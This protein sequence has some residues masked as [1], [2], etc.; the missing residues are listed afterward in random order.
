MG[1]TTINDVMAAYDAF[2]APKGHDIDPLNPHGLNDWRTTENPWLPFMNFYSIFTKYAAMADPQNA[3]AR[4][5]PV[6]PDYKVVGGIV[7]RDKLTDPGDSG[8]FVYHWGRY[9]QTHGTPDPWVKALKTQGP[10]ESL[11]S[12]RSPSDAMN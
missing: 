2:V 11:C 8:V 6:T 12:S 4:Y 5:Y 7:P 10:E 1:G 3:P 9:M